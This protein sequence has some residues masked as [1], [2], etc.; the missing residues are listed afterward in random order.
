MLQGPA[1]RLLRGLRSHVS[2]SRCLPQSTH[3]SRHCLR[4]ARH[5]CA[6][7]ADCAVDRAAPLL[8]AL[9][10][11]DDATLDPYARVALVVDGGPAMHAFLEEM[12]ACKRL[13]ERGVCDFSSVADGKQIVGVF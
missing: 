7:L 1:A 10:L 3:P 9:A 5:A 8:D 12:A 2:V 11:E 4:R 13:E 6:L